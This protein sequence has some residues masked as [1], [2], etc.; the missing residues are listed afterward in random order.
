MVGVI[1][2]H[3]VAS[4]PQI[5]TEQTENKPKLLISETSLAIL[6]FFKISHM[7]ILSQCD[8]DI[9]SLLVSRS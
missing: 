4:S 2:N 9:F 8:H 3:S 1:I 6:H 5:L 7:C